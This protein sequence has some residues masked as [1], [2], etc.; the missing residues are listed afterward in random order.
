MSSGKKFLLVVIFLLLMFGISA[1]FSS[2]P[3]LIYFGF[4]PAQVFYLLIVHFL[5]MAFIG[6]LAFGTRL[7]GRVEDEKQFLDEVRR[8]R[9]EVGE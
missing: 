3:N 1:P 8:A 4:L 7:H 9:K 2:P 6:Y 5:W